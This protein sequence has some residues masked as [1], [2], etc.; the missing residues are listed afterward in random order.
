MNKASGDIFYL[1]ILQ[2]YIYWYPFYNLFLD[3]KNFLQ[4]VYLD[5]HYY[6]EMSQVS[7]DYL[8]QMQ[9][10]RLGVC[11]INSSITDN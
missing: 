2:V 1:S 10:N 9:M 8:L 6:Y 5:Q 4:I 3:N 7:Q 11:R